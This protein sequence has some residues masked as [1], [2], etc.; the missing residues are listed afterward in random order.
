M[1]KLVAEEN[2]MNLPEGWLSW[3]EP[4]WMPGMLQ[5]DRQGC[6]AWRTGTS[7]RAPTP[8]GGPT[9]SGYIDIIQR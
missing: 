3:T 1:D 4:D 8:P 5:G 7:G 2:H 6:R 9:P